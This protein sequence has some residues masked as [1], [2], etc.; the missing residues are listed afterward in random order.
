VA[1]VLDN[2]WS[3][4]RSYCGLDAI[5]YLRTA[6]ESFVGYMDDD[7]DQMSLTLFSTGAIQPCALTH[8]FTAPMVARIRTMT[9]VNYTDLSDGMED[10]Y[11]QL[12]A[13]LNPSSFRAVVFFTDGR[14]TTLHDRFVV[15]GAPVDAIIAGDQEP[16]G[17]VYNQLYR[18]DQLNQA[19][20]GVLY[21][22]PLFPDG[23]ERNVVNLQQQ[24][25]AK[26]LAAAQRARSE[27]MTVYTIG[28]G[29]PNN[30]QP[31]VVPDAQLLIEV[32]NVPFGVDPTTGAT[33][34]NPTYDPREPQGGFYF[35]PDATGL[36]TVFERVAQEIVLRLTQ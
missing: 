21:T 10:G 4:D 28:L 33:I 25:S 2:S 14:P 29:N 22:N 19:M 9:A 18:P 27:G 11:Q 17:H 31:W 3:M 20:P 30:L 8:N 12:R 26:F 24:A 13:D 35:A 32:A 5:G 15:N 6:S 7:M 23:S 34:V 16:F 36:Q 1:L